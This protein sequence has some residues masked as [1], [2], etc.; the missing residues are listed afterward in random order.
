MKQYIEKSALVA[1][2]ER[3][4]TELIEEGEDTMFE[5][6]RISA[7]EDVKV[8]INHTLE[9]KDDVDTIHNIDDVVSNDTIANS[10]EISRHGNSHN[11][12]TLEEAARSYS[13]NIDNICGSVGEQTRN[14]FKA[15]AKWQE[16]H[17]IDKA[18]EWLKEQDEMVGV[19]FE[20]NFI[21]RFKNYMK[22][23]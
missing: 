19:S 2:I 12:E 4:I 17:L 11:G 5:Q 13:D 18:C 22:G 6:G 9:V 10:L 14:A 8:F 3:L 16:E 15:G 23:E 1:E 20:E 21:E 7:L